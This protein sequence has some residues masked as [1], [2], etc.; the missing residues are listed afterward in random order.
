[1]GG[2]YFQVQPKTKRMIGTTTRQHKNIVVFFL[3]FANRV[4]NDDDATKISHG[5][6]F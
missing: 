6:G 2:I 3:K 4:S 1:M 5:H